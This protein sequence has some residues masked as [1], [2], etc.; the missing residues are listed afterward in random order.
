[1]NLKKEHSIIALLFLM[2]LISGCTSV[3]NPE[4]TTTST[5]TTIPQTEDTSE[6]I[7]CQT[8]EDCPDG[9]ECIEGICWA[10]E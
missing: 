6:Y 1:M 4:T 10:P 7:P 8:I 5:S 2:V 9:Y 3:L